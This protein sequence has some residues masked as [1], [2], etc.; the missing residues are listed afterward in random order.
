MLQ[1]AAGLW[2]SSGRGVGTGEFG[3]CSVGGPVRK[4]S[5]EVSFVFRNAEVDQKHPRDFYARI[6]QNMFLLSCKNRK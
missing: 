1:I 4:S 3:L 2:A 5:S 6:I